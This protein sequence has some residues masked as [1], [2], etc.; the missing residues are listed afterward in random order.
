[1]NI[2]TLLLFCSCHAFHVSSTEIYHNRN[3]QLEIMS[4]VFADDLES[5]LNHR[6][7]Q[8]DVDIFSSDSYQEN[9]ESLQE[10]IS[11]KLKIVQSRRDLDISL[12]GYE[13]SENRCFLYMETEHIVGEVIL[14][15]NL[16]V[17]IFPDQKN[18]ILFS[19]EKTTASFLL[20]REGL[21]HI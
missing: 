21:F 6:S 5:A 4:I 8:K 18:L 14:S 20:K 2:L 19:A 1:M 13:I 17:D 3:G 11:S 9:L 16:L 15:Y 12:L 7:D 10:Y